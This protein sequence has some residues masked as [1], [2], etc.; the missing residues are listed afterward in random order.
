MKCNDWSLR[1]DR[2]FLGEMRMIGDT[3]IPLIPR[4]TFF[5]NAEALNP[6]LSPDG[7]WLAW[8]AA[9]DGVMNV[10]VAPRDE[11]TKAR[12]LTRQTNR[13]I[14]AHWF[15]RTN[16]HVLFRKDK[17][18]DENFNLWCVGIDGSDARNLTPYPDVLAMSWHAPREP[19]SHC[20]RHERPRRTMARPLRRRHP[21]GE[22]RLVYENADEIA[23]FVLDS[24]LNLRLATTMR[25]KGADRR[26]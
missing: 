23:S 10:W 18:G 21:T 17:D 6:L 9:V 19:A 20:R 16:A 1:E 26:S 24:Q 13:P 5:E 3:S 22:R 14:L 15:A 25:N 2:I 4:K 8:I 12:P 11:L 7:R